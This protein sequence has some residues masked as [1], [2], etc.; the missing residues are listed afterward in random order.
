[1][2][3]CS[4]SRKR[5]TP[6]MA[7]ITPMISTMLMMMKSP[8]LKAFRSFLG[9]TEFPISNMKSEISNFKSQISDFRSNLAAKQID[10]I[11]S[12]AAA[13]GQR[14]DRRAVDEL[15]HQRV[16]AVAHFVGRAGC[17]ELPAIEQHHSIG[18]AKR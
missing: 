3:I 8:A 7:T 15:L 14:A 12:A 6:L 13:I 9:M 5:P 10:F 4:G 2:R 16:V 18:N 17:D 1:M 11:L